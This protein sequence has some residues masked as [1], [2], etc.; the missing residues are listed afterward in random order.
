MMNF[1]RSIS[2]AAW[3]AGRTAQ[4]MTVMTAAKVCGVVRGSADIPWSE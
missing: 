3:R 2:G 4:D 1:G